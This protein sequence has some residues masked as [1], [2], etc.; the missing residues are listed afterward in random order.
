MVPL[1]RC[2]ATSGAGS[3]HSKR[4]AAETATMLSTDAV[5]TGTGGA[6]RPSSRNR[7]ANWI[8]GVADGPGMTQ[9]SLASS[10]MEG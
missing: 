6:E 3:Q 1:A 9:F 5:S 2:G 7:A 10:I 4:L 8:R